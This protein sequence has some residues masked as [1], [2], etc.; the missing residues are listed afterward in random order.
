MPKFKKSVYTLPIIVTHYI[1]FVNHFFGKKQQKVLFSYAKKCRF[2]FGS[3]DFVGLHKIFKII[4]SQKGYNLVTFCN[5]FVIFMH[6]AQIVTS[7]L[8]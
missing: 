6:I 3:A 7:F 1:V 8:V 2:A 4:A 5:N